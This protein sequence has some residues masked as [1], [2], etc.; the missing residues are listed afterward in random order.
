MSTSDP[1][2][3]KRADLTERD[4]Q[5]TRWV[6]IGIVVWVIIALTALLGALI[7]VLVR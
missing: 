6:A 5:V 3:R 7:Y 2:L 1:D 4:R